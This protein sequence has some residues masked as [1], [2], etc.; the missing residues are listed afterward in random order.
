MCTDVVVDFALDLAIDRAV[1]RAVADGE[2]RLSGV[3]V[4]G[5]PLDR[6]LADLGLGAAARRA[7]TLVGSRAQDCLAPLPALLVEL[8]EG[9]GSER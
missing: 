2:W 6:L 5:H 4:E 9:A 1:G 7:A 3:H 8:L